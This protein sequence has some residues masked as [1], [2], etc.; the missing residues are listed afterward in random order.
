M[1]LEKEK[2]V[3]LD[4]RRARKLARELGLRVIG[5]LSILRRLYELGV[6]EINP[7]VLYMRLIEMGFY[8]R[9]DVFDRVFRK[10]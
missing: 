10:D 2:T 3:V 6:L 9:K 1:A 5:T 7:R 4:D 8:V